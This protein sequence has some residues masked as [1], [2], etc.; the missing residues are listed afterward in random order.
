[1]NLTQKFKNFIFKKIA[2]KIYK[3]ELSN[4][5]IHKILLIRD[6]GIGDVICSYPLMR[7]LKKIFPYATIDV[8]ASLNNH[9]MFEY[10][11]YINN[12]YLKYKKRQWYKTWLDI[13][14]MRLNKYDLAIDDTVIR[15]HRTIYTMFINPKFALASNGSKQKYGFD[16]SELSFYYKTYESNDIQHI[17]DKRLRVLK[18]LD[19]NYLIDNSMEFFFPPNSNQEIKQRLEKIKQYKLIGLNTLGS[20]KD[21]TLKE[22]QIVKICSLL[23]KD[24]TRIII[25]SLPK[26][27]TYLI[28]LIKKNTL[29]NVE[30]PIITKTIYD[31]AQIVNN[32]D[33]IISPDTSFIH[34][35]SALNI[36]TIGL[37]W[38]N[39]MKYI[40]WGPRS[41]KFYS[42]TPKKKE[43]NL[44]NIDLEEV[45]EKALKI[46]N[47]L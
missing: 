28:N 21:R 13:Y 12:I 5:K 46:I 38:N 42:I 47:I 27:E 1:M 15:F 36:P 18:F 22:E 17:V 8:Y 9:F 20:S 34:I 39:P 37:F 26:D 16:R 3:E 43:S 29:Q 2:Q 7:E 24:N 45:K 33:L 35:A 30:L 41:D 10:V 14:K 4:D 19:I 32:L 6:G 25:F 23:E 11:P 31:A 40:E 44:E